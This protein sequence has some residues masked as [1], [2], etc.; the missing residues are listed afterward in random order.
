MIIKNQPLGVQLA[1]RLRREILD[2]TR[3]AGDLLIENT[4]SA[5]FGLSR[6][7]VRDAF[8]QLTQEGLIE[9]QGRSYRVSEFT[10]DDVRELYDLRFSLERLAVE[11]AMHSAPDWSRCHKALESMHTAAEQGDAA[12]FALA[13]LEFH[14][15]FYEATPQRRVTHASRT[16]E[17]TLEVLLELTPTVKNDMPSMT[18]EHR[19][20]LDAIEANDSR[21]PGLLKAHLDL[22]AAKLDTLF[23]DRAASA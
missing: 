23:P 8:R 10:R 15:G 19:E 20:I 21:W 18:V 17:R 9:M 11:R 16:I 14:R 6:G 13:D 12:A 1:K 2:G 7:P 3:S 22:G 5:E 4:L